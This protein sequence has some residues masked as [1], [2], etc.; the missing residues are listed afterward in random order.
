MNF[1]IDDLR[2]A[3]DTFSAIMQALSDLHSAGVDRTNYGCQAMARM[4][5]A[6]ERALTDAGF[7]IDKISNT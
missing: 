3:Q 1:T 4:T 5:V 7:I 6:L 2:T